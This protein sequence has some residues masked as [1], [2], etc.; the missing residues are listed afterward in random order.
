MTLFEALAAKIE[1][2]PGEPLLF[3]RRDL[4]WGW[5]PY[6]WVPEVIAELHPILAK[7]APGARIAFAEAPSLPAFAL[8]MTLLD[9]GWVSV[10]LPESLMAEGRGGADAIA[11]AR[12]SFAGRVPKIALEV[13]ILKAQDETKTRSGPGGVAVAVEEGRRAVRP[14]S[15]LEEA[16]AALSEVVGA[17]ES[18]GLAPARDILLSWRPW[19]IASERALLAWA[20]ASGAAIIFEPQRA[21]AAATV[22]WL[23]PTV[24]QGSGSELSSLADRL[25]SARGSM[26]RRRLRRLRTVLVDGGTLAESA[27]TFYGRLEARVVD[28]APALPAS[29]QPVL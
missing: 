6:R 8:D 15:W 2:A 14:L 4:D 12:L 10:P 24:L 25:S 23:G 18:T 29:N 11:T 19:S 5:L 16:A 3:Y 20:L 7:A 17:A 26:T 21:A 9:G 13:E 28:L 22:G 1:K 27:R